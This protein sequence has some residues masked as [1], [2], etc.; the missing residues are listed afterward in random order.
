MNRISYL[1]VLLVFIFLGSFWSNGLQAQS[2][3]SFH[4]S[5]EF[6]YLY[7]THSTKFRGPSV[8]I[9]KDL[10]NHWT[11]GLGVGYNFCPFH[12]DN[13]FD[14]KDL[15]LIP[16]YGLVQYRFSHHRLFDPYATFKTGVTLLNYKQ[17]DASKNDSYANIHSKGWYTYLGGGTFVNLNAIYQ[18]YINVGLIGYK[19]S[20]NDLDIN[21]HGVS[22]N[23][24]IRVKI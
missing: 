22:G 1:L 17:K 20:F 16:I 18:L 5:A 2:D 12:P 11:L 6:N 13:G 3:S 19:M 8:A 24:G 9:D 15:K 14:L 4:I 10:N 23:I 21:P 7:S